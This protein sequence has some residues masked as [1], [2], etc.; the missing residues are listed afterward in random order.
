MKTAFTKAYNHRV[1]LPYASSGGTSKRKAVVAEND[2]MEGEEQESEESEKEDN[3]LSKNSMIK[4]KQRSTKS[5]KGRD[6][7]AGTSKKARG[8]KK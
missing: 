3:D 1:V 6:E 2:T 7:T 4:V 8:K 5:K